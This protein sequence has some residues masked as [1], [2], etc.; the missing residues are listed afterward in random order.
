MSRSGAAVAPRNVISAWYHIGS[1]IASPRKHSSPTEAGGSLS[2]PAGG[3]GAT[4]RAARGG[5]A[6]PGSG[7]AAANPLS[8]TEQNRREGGHRDPARRPARRPTRTGQTVRPGDGP[9][10]GSWA[11]RTGGEQQ[12]A[13]APGGHAANGH[14]PGRPPTGRTAVRPGAGGTRGGGDGRGAAC[15]A[16]QDQPTTTDPRPA[17]RI[18]VATPTGARPPRIPKKSRR[19]MAPRAGHQ[20]RDSGPRTGARGDEAGRVMCPARRHGLADGGHLQS[21][22]DRAEGAVFCRA[23]GTCARREARPT[24]G[25]LRGRASPPPSMR[26]QPHLSAQRTEGPQ[27]PEGF[28]GGTHLHYLILGRYSVSGMHP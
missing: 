12:G 9:Q 24:G 3:R 16:G 6:P 13:D 4:R 10:G 7:G 17:T 5:P 19:A 2:C 11:T 20:R 28:L 25:A 23:R 14:R 18:R 22:D 26:R 8:T 27:A 15:G 21:I 1:H